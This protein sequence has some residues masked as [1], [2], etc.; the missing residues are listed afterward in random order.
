NIVVIGGVAG[1]MS[2]ATR[3]RRLNPEDNITIIEKGQYVSFA[4]CGL[5]YYLGGEIK[6]RDKLLVANIDELRHNFN[7]NILINSEVIEIIK[8][9]QEVVIK[10]FDGSIDKLK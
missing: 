6:K 10:F 9:N 4:N 8:E 1:G 2:F 5:P 3:Y 7:F